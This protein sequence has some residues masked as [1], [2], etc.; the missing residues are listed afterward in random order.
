MND[1]FEMQ[2]FCGE[3]G[4][5]LPQI[6]AGLRP[7]DR[8]CAYA[9]P[10]R[11]RLAAFQNKPKEVVVLAH[12]KTYRDHLRAKTKKSSRYSLS[13]LAKLFLQLL[14]A[15]LQS[16]QTQLPPVQLDTELIDVTR[17]LGSLRFVFLELSSQIRNQSLRFGR[18]RFMDGNRRNLGGLSAPLTR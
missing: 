15:F 6:E 9:G 2:L 13:G 11:S 3:Q 18:Q 1:G 5:R 16:L 17:D 12:A 10:I 4:K 14:P 8:D 7:E